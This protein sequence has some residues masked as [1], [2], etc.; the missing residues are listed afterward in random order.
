[1]LKKH[2]NTENG[3]VNLMDQV[4]SWLLENDTPEIKYRTTVE[5]LGKSKE[6]KE[7]KE[8][9]NQLLSSNCL[10]VVME[11]FKS[12]NKWEH[13]N[14]LLALAEFGLT[15]EDVMIDEYVE[16]II[17]KLNR[18][19]KCAKVLLLRNLVALGY[20]EHSWV[21]DEIGKA[22]SN[23][24]EDGTVR[25]LDTGKKRNDSRLPEMG[26]YRQITTYL[27]LGAEL[28]KKGIIL[29]ELDALVNFY[30][31]HDVMFHSEDLEKIIIKDMT[32]TFYPI[33]HVHIG[34]QMI[35]YG[36]SI[37]SNGNY[38]NY[39]KAW[40]LLDSYRNSEG[41]YILT[42]S[43]TEPC[44]NVGTVEEANKWVT[45]YVLLAKMYYS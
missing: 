3:K 28:K 33:D 17:K 7:V 39:M 44:F 9:Y 5:L 26:C 25:C 20:Y 13:V 19:M 6:N 31:S 36:L 29:R 1:M 40:D 45:L 38:E 24:R 15:R 4:I 8:S 35:M 30:I 42:E 21:Q 27:L 32:G 14:A 23:I 37:V 12:N 34:L 16:R 11:K 22:L 43:F 2:L 18:S 41:R 10:S